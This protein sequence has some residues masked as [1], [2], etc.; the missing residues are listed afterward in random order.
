MAEEH[1][2]IV[3]MGKMNVLRRPLVSQRIYEEEEAS[4]PPELNA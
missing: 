1:E 4:I 2:E 3:G